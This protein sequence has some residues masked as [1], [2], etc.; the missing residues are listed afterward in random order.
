MYHKCS[1]IDRIELSQRS[2]SLVENIVTVQ[3]T[4]E[5]G[6]GYARGLERLVGR[7]RRGTSPVRG[8]DEGYRHLETATPS[9]TKAPHGSFTEPAPG[10]TETPPT[11][12]AW[13]RRRTRCRCEGACR[14][15]DAVRGETGT[16]D[17]SRRLVHRH[18]GAQAGIRRPSALTVPAQ[19]LRDG[20][21]VNAETPS[22]RDEGPA[23]GVHPGDLGRNPLIDGV[24]PGVAES[25]L[26]RDPG[27]SA[28]VYLSRPR[29]RRS[30]TTVAELRGTGPIRETETR[31]TPRRLPR[32]L[33]GSDNEHT[34]ATKPRA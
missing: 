19:S 18:A 9:R 31:A 33:A 20:V 16:D 11:S 8:A 22:D 15:D 34:E 14:S 21:I 24:R 4:E 17:H 7:D 28:N 26:Q 3:E 25:D 2:K 27:K 32:T 29:T 13:A 5:L 23:L 12:A 6:D 10:G 1:T 30:Q